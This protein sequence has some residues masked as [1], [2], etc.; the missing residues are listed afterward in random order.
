MATNPAGHLGFDGRLRIGRYD[1]ELQD[2]HAVRFHVA[3]VGRMVWL[4]WP[5]VLPKEAGQMTRPVDG[6]EAAWQADSTS[7]WA[8]MGVAVRMVEF[9]ELLCS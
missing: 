9:S 1:V 8:A 7:S 4:H 6:R 3:G 2:P 5:A